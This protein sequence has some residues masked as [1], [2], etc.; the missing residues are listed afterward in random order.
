MITP[1]RGKEPTDLQVL[2]QLLL[3]ARAADAKR[4]ATDDYV[5]IEP[6]DVAQIAAT[7]GVRTNDLYARLEYHLNAVYRSKHGGDGLL[8]FQTP[9]VSLHVSLAQTAALYANLQAEERRQSWTQGIAFEAL[10]VSILSLGFSVGKPSDPVRIEVV[11]SP[12]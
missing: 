5:F 12:S 8:T 9:L 3:A 10:A 11:P 1:A 6:K 7:L 4:E 2:R